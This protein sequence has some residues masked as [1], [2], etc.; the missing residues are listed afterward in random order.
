MNNNRRYDEQ[1]MAMR[2]Q[3]S[4]FSSMM[5]NH[6][7]T[8]ITDVLCKIIIDPFKFGNG[9]ADLFK[10]QTVFECPSRKNQFQ[11]NVW[12]SKIWI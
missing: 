9:I 5:T 3:L 1:R 12:L 8:C 6:H 4:S 11:N 2:I 7:R 10:F